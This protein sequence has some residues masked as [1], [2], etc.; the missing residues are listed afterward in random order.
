MKNLWKE[1]EKKN[2]MMHIRALTQLCFPCFSQNTFNRRKRKIF[3]EVQSKCEE[4]LSVENFFEI[5]RD[6][7][8][9]KFFYFDEFQKKLLKVCPT[10]NKPNIDD[11]NIFET[12][13]P[14]LLEN[15]NN[16]SESNRL[17]KRV[18]DYF[19]NSNN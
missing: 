17:N 15:I 18:L 5:S 7:N 9:Y 8:F 13:L 4:V 14:S 19:T 10:P 6:V 3:I 1:K 16:Q 2:Y 12:N 11:P